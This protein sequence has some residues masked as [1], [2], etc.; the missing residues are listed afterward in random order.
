MDMDPFYKSVDAR[1][2]SQ[3]GDIAEVKR[4]SL[5]RDEW[6]SWKTELQPMQD[7]VKE[8]DRQQKS[9][10]ESLDALKAEALGRG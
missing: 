10:M 5:Q 1:F 3:A 6:E 8:L 4:A 7:D 9:T 2:A